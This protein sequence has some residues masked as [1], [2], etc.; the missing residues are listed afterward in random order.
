[1][2]PEPDVSESEINQGFSGVAGRHPFPEES[3]FGPERRFTSLAEGRSTGIATSGTFEF[4]RTASSQPEHH[5]V[6]NDFKVSPTNAGDTPQGT[7]TR[8]RSGTRVFSR[9]G[10]AL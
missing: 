10:A 7:Q 5:H 2:T 9:S 4:T 1:M 6:N 8:F 3:P